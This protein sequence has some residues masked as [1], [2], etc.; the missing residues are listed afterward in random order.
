MEPKV[1][2]DC[3]AAAGLQGSIIDPLVDKYSRQVQKLAASVAANKRAL[4]ALYKSL[5]ENDLSRKGFEVKKNELIIEA[6]RIASMSNKG[7]I[8]LATAKL[9]KSIATLAASAAKIKTF[10]NKA[11]KAEISKLQASLKANQGN[12]AAQRAMLSAAQAA[13]IR[14]E[15]SASTMSEK[16]SEITSLNI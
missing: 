11:V 9:D 5:K 8:Q 13:V 6:S 2:G 7:K 10:D 3:L 15:A 14:K 4:G 12:L 16:L 1:L